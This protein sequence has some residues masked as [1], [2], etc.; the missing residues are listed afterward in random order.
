MRHAL[1]TLALCASFCLVTS[2]PA[3]AQADF[4]LV[5]DQPASAFTWGG[6]SSLGPIVGNPSNAFELAGTVGL[7]AAPLGTQSV[8]TATFIPTGDVFTVPGLHGKIPNTF[9]FLPPLATIDITNLHMTMSSSAFA[10]AG[11]GA[12]TGAP[13]LTMLSGTMTV[14]PLIGTP[15]VTDLAGQSSSPTPTTGT[16][17]QP[18][19]GLHLVTPINGT[20]PFDDPASGVSGSVTLLGTLV[21]NWTCPTPAAY[22]TA[23]VNSLGCTPAI[24]STGQPSFS[25]A[26]PFTIEASM[27]LNGRSGIMFYGYGQQ[28]TPFQGGTMCVTAPVKRTPVQDSGGSAVGN[29]CTG[30]FSF[31]MNGRIQSGLDGA[32]VPG[33]EVFAQ[34][35]SRD[36]QSPGTTN[37]TDALAFTVCP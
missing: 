33:A 19:G 31:E 24:G 11:G 26:A 27:I 22:C 12:W 30:V 13:V 2:S 9:A 10:V 14:T 35:W 4:T 34:F 5:V 3:S 23:K 20:F 21:A 6:T 7:H 37:L 25:S 15:T 36:P 17:E 8:G 28:A 16:L 18:G 29:D 32:L 1:S